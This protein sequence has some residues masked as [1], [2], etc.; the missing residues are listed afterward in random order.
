MK[1]IVGGEE[2]AQERTHG[3]LVIES[4]I[5]IDDKILNRNQI[6]NN[7]IMEIIYLKSLL[8]PKSRYLGE[9]RTNTFRL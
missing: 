5:V 3:S 8:I 6:F 1:R 2:N 7:Y 9:R 4:F